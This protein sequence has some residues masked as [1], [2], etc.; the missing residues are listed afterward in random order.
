MIAASGISRQPRWRDALADA[1][2]QMPG[3]HT[4]QAAGRDAAVDLCFL[5]ASH[6]YAEDFGVLLADAADATG[7]RCIVGCSGQGIIGAEREIEGDPALALL[8]LR[9]PGADV[10]PVRITQA[11]LERR[12]GPDDWRSFTGVPPERA[13]A[14]FLFADPF[15]LDAEALLVA[16][17]QAYPK[18]PLIGGMASGDARH[19]RT[20]VFLNRQVYESGGVALAMGGAYGLRTVV[21]QGCMPIGRPWTIT[22]ADGQLLQTI[23]RRPAYEVLV[24]TLKTLPPEV[25]DRARGNLFVGLAMDEYREELGRGDFLIRNIVGVDLNS[26]ALA[27]SALPRVGQTMQFQIRD[28]ATADQDLNELLAAAATSAGQPVAALL[29]SCNGRGIGLFGAPHH[30][31]GVL[32]RRLGPLPVAGFFCNGEIGPVGSR[33]FLHGFTASIAL[34]VPTQAQEITL[35]LALEE[36]APADAPPAE[37]SPPPEGESPPGEAPPGA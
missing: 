34:I 8:A 15:T 1:L 4:Q 14:W 19:R 13:N 35:R 21:S 6:A 36:A 32:A 27:V 3:V 7:A 29:C 33:N 5:F 12:Q 11:D 26:G 16:L 10:R 18:T 23:A 9:L 2:A 30:D 28:R 22:G 17:S 20:H 31:A 37:G 25:Q 24:D